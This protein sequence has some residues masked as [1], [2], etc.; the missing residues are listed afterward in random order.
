[1][2]SILRARLNSKEN[3]TGLLHRVPP[4]KLATLT[5]GVI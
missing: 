3:K 1:M 5:A 4:R 2:P